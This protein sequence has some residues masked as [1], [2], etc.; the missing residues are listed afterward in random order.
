MVE[1]QLPKLN[2]VG[3]SPIIRSKPKSPDSNA[4]RGFLFAP[5]LELQQI[6]GVRPKVGWTILGR[7]GL[8][9]GVKLG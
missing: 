9:I 6:S 1:R 2:V 5:D 8:V 3:S 7:F 4:F